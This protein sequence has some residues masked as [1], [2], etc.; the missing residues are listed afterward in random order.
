MALHVLPHIFEYDP[1][2]GDFGLGF[3]GHSLESASYLVYDDSSFEGT[4]QW[5]CYLC[6]FVKGRPPASIPLSSMAIIPRD[7]YRQRVFLEPLCLYIEL[8]TGSIKQLSIDFL[9]QNLDIWYDQE[10]DRTFD[11]FRLRLKKTCDTN[12]RPGFDFL[13]LGHSKEDM[14]RGAYEFPYSVSST[15]VRVSWKK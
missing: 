2:S 11:V 5:M 12:V 8:D 13:P 14:V 15:F 10:K 7:S 6:D 3:F 1:H 4:G 9:N